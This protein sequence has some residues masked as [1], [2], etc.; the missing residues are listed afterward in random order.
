MSAITN[1]KQ[2]LTHM[3]PE[4]RSTAEFVFCTFRDKKYGAYAELE[5]LCAFQEK[6]GLT[7]ILPRAQ[8]DRAGISYDGSYLIITLQVH[9]SLE[10]VGLTAAV[11]AK[12][13]DHNISANIVAAYHHDH[14]FVATAQAEQA[15]QALRELSAESA[16]EG[17][18]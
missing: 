1:L 13:T 5:P 18:R 9:S 14:I 2:L 8:A 12:L 7:L 4:L 3:E 10:A 11:A 6:E 17:S 15:V 16:R